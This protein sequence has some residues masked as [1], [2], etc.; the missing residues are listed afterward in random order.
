MSKPIIAA[1]RPVRVELEQGRRYA[2]CVCGRSATQPFCD[3]SHRETDLRPLMFQARDGG[4]AFLCRCKQTANPPYCD[5]S[6]KQVS[7][8]AVGGEG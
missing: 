8:D 7:D 1:N 2:F 6:H 5:G 4:P 3:G